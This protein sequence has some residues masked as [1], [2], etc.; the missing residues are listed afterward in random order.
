[1][2]EVAPPADRS[3]AVVLG[4]PK[5]TTALQARTEA[6]TCPSCGLHVALRGG[7]LMDRNLV[8]PPFEATEIKVTGSNLFTRTRSVVGRESIRSGDLDPVTGH[9]P[10]GENAVAWNDVWTI[11]TWKRLDV[12]LLLATILLLGPFDLLLI[13]GTIGQPGVAIVA[14]PMLAWTFFALRKAI[15]TGARHMRVCG[16]QLILTL[17]YDTLSSKWKRFEREAH[18]RAGIP[19]PPEK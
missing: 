11:T 3:P 13:A 19:L 14:V 7:C 6:Q 1:M 2:T 16:S 8:P 17:R 5:C 15:K 10:I 9:I 18:K 4:C 12:K